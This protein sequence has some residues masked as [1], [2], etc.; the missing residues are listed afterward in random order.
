M[1]GSEYITVDDN[2]LTRVGS[3]KWTSVISDNPLPSSGV[4]QFEVEL[5]NI[6]QIDSRMKYHG[7]MF[8]LSSTLNPI[9]DG[10]FWKPS[11]I[12]FYIMT[13]HRGS[14]FQPDSSNKYSR[15]NNF[16]SM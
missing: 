9:P 6:G 1:V 15:Q 3:K 12:M 5:L 14:I 7:F 11:A 16:L 8:G 13:A 2:L 4:F 10:T